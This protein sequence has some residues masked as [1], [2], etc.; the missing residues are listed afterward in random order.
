MDPLEA[1]FEI[2]VF[3]YIA[4]SR[5]EILL[6]RD[7][8]RENRWTLPGGGVLPGELLTDAVCRE[9]REELNVQVVVDRLAGIFSQRKR[10][11][12]VA[13]FDAHIVGGKPRPDNVETSD[14][15]FFSWTAIDRLR[16]EIK[17]AQFSMIY[18]RKSSV[19]GDPIFGF[20]ITP[21]ARDSETAAVNIG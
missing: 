9:V 6:A 20:F 5:D 7:A 3:A 21:P 19:V 1:T 4:N 12:I 10:P 11:G 17:P 16:E 2:G 8:T 18:Q 15:R 13:L 14:C